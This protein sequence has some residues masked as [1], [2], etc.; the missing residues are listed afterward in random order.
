[1]RGFGAQEY[2]RF[3]SPE[4]IVTLDVA[5]DEIVYFLYE[6][7]RMTVEELADVLI[8]M[9]AGPICSPEK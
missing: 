7:R 1:M 8:K 6:R 3:P 5:A 4:S 2:D 9:L